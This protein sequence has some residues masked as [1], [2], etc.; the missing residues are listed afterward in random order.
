MRTRACINLEQRS[1]RLHLRGVVVRDRVLPAKAG[2]AQMEEL[3][4]KRLTPCVIL[5]PVILVLG[6]RALAQ[7]PTRPDP[8]A[9][10][11]VELLW[12]VRVPLRDGVNLNATVYKPQQMSDPLPVI[13]TL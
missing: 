6:L 7:V 1:N 10:K 8:A 3:F 12:G 11:E 4:V 13:F 9:S 5:I 2:F